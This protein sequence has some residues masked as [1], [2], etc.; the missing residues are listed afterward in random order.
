MVSRGKDADGLSQAGEEFDGLL[1]LFCSACG[2]PMDSPLQTVGDTAVYCL[3]CAKLRDAKER[4]RFDRI[5]FDLH[6]VENPDGDTHPA[7]LQ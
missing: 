7:G 6:N 3:A 2:K 1:N 4:T 5:D